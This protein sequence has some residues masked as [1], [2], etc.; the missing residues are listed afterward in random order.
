MYRAC[1]VQRERE[2]SGAGRRGGARGG[3][4]Q[5]W[6]R[7]GGGGGEGGEGRGGRDYRYFE[8]SV[9]GESGVGRGGVVRV[10]SGEGVSR[11]ASRGAVGDGAVREVG[12]RRSV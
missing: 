10:W 9:G 3:T 11:V 6:A 7:G 8:G 4:R 2:R 12:W 1:G 5:G